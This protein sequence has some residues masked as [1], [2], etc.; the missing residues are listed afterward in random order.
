MKN[1]QKEFEIIVSLCFK[2]PVKA[3]SV[4]EAIKKLEDKYIHGKGR[5]P[6][7]FIEIDEYE[8]YFCQIGD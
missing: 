2:E 7:E 6:R 3:N 5:L 1:K 8:D 4:E